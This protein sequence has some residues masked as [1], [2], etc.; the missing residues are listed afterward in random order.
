MLKATAIL[1]VFFG[2]SDNR[3]TISEKFENIEQCETA[4]TAI[5]E[6]YGTYSGN[7]RKAGHWV[8]PDDS[9][10]VYISK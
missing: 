9:G 8:N 3:T 5:K 4:Y 6:K 10:C 7:L 1:I 2:A